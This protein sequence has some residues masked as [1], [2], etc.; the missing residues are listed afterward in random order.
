VAGRGGARPRLGGGPRIGAPP[1]NR[2]QRGHLKLWLL[3]L[4]RG[5]RVREGVS[6]APRH[7]SSEWT[8]GSVF[9]EFWSLQICRTGKMHIMCV[10]MEK[11]LSAR[12]N[13]GSCVSGL[14]LQRKPLCP[15]HGR[16][17]ASRA[18]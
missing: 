11:N 14:F 13:F 7:G 15:G 16:K 1:V 10:L 3:A 2:R 5:A 8:A 9:R 12:G 4:G 6:A 17:A 18:Y